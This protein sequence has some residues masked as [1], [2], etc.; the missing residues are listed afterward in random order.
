MYVLPVHVLRPLEEQWLI[1]VSAKSN[2]SQALLPPDCITLKDSSE[3]VK[4]WPLVVSQNTKYKLQVALFLR[5]G[6]F[7]TKIRRAEAYEC[8]MQKNSCQF[9][10]TLKFYS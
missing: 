3:T 5:E 6:R 7:C 2:T 4:H 1:D 8:R 9:V 10:F